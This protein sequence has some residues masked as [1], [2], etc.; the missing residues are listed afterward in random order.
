EAAI[1]VEQGRS[2]LG[3]AK[4]V[5]QRSW[6]ALNEHDARRIGLESPG[7]SPADGG[8]AWSDGDEARERSGADLD[9]FHLQWDASEAAMEEERW[10]DAAR[11]LERLLNQKRRIP[12]DEVARV[13]RRLAAIYV[14]QALQLKPL[15]GSRRNALQAVRLFDKAAGLDPAQPAPLYRRGGI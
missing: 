8:N 3:A 1:A 11:V 10:Q 5:E 15:E 7:G 9:F 12:A 6:A 4:D 2:P 13:Q 14:H